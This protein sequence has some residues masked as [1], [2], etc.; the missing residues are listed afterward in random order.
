MTDNTTT[1]TP[2]RPELAI[3]DPRS[4]RARSSWHIR[5]P[6]CRTAGLTT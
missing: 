5:R 2:D 6:L 4:W 3:F 1:A